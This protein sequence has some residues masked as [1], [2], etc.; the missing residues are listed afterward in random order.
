MSDPNLTESAWQRAMTDAARIY[1]TTA[2]EVAA[3]LMT[4][5]FGAIAAVV[6]AGEDT[7]TQIAIPILGGAVA[8]LTTFA[9]VFGFQL[10]AAPIRQRNELRQ[11]WSRPAADSVQPVNVELSLRDFRRRGDDLLN[12]F[13]RGYT[14]EDEETAERWT[15]ETIQFLSQHCDPA[16]A[17]S[18]ID[19]SRG[20]T[21]FFPSF[22]AR[23][24]ALNGIIANVG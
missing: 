8:L 7:T 6:S 4:I 3:T 12:S 18:F 22:E 14:T 16:L 13:R 24:A 10:I 17:Q 11:N 23:I 1:P 20:Q 15:G 9:V 5:I 2:F 21:A 19:A